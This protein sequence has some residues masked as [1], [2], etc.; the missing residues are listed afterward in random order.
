MEFVSA[1]Q[2]SDG[3]DNNNLAIVEFSYCNPFNESL[4]LS[5][6]L[7]QF[8]NR[9]ITMDQ[10]WQPGGKGGTA[11]GFGASVYDCS[12]VL[13]YFLETISYKV[14]DRLLYFFHFLFNNH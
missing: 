7:F 13:S 12:I 8:E 2:L 4:K 9:Q 3:V 10:Q 11:I 1:N 14:A 5:N 6:R